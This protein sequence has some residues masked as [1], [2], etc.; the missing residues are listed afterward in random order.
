MWGIYLDVT[1]LENLACHSDVARSLAVCISTENYI[2]LSAAAKLAPGRPS[3][4]TIWRWCRNGIKARNGEQI[5]LRH[6]RV[7]GRIY[8]TP[9]AL[10][11][12]FIDVADADV[13]H[14]DATPQ[15]QPREK[16]IDGDTNS[17]LSQAGIL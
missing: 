13:E 5:R 4:C 3:S 12:F 10:E 6:F 9:D 16:Q 8:T 15:E 1:Q 11:T 17:T 2:T 7:G 14:F